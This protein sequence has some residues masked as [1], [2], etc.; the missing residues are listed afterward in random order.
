MFLNLFGN[1]YLLNLRKPD[2]YSPLTSYNYYLIY[3]YYSY[4][5]IIL[6]LIYTIL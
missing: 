4:R 1:N 2:L 5:T 6:H 3:Y